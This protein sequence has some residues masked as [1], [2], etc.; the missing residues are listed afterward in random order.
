VINVDSANHHRLGGDVDGPELTTILAVDLES[1]LLDDRA[2]LLRLAD[3]LAVDALRRNG[4]LGS[5]ERL[6]GTVTVSSH[7]WEDAHNQLQLENNIN[8]N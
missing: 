4:K 5:A 8:M 1:Y 6:N 3:R 7:G 2:Q